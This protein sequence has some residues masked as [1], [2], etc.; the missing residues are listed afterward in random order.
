[1]IPGGAFHEVVGDVSIFA[2]ADDA[3]VREIDFFA[4][5]GTV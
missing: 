4:S 2:P 3:L 5:V 1:M